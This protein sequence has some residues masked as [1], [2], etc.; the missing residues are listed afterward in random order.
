MNKI[1]ICPNEEKLNI[2][3]KLNNSNELHNIKF[4]TIKEYID[5]YY[6]SYNSNYGSF[7]KETYPMNIILF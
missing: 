2:L 5:S 4:M 6:F 7:F 3:D 1:V